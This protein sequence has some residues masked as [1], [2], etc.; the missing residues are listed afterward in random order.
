MKS[1]CLHPGLLL[2]NTFVS[3]CYSYSFF[4]LYSSSLSHKSSFWLSHPSYLFLSLS[5]AISRPSR[6]DFPSNLLHSTFRRLFSDVFN[7]SICL[8]TNHSDFFPSHSN[9]NCGRMKDGQKN[10]TIQKRF[11]QSFVHC[12]ERTR[13]LVSL[14]FSSKPQKANI[15]FFWKVVVA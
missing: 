8:R 6:A 15:T 2:T 3:Y 4:N 14:M 13:N 9:R 12:R 11:I 1:H 10:A 7:R 5:L